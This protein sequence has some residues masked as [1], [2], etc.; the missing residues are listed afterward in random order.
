MQSYSQ[1]SSLWLDLASLV[2]QCDT[3]TYTRGLEL[4]RNQRVL[5][6]SIEPLKDVW[7]VMGDV[8]GSARHP[9]EVSIEVKRSPDGRVMEWDSDCTCPVGYQCKHGVALMIKAA[10][11]GQQ[12]LGG[13]AVT[14][15]AKPLTAQE[16]EAQRQA[17]LDKRQAAAQRQPRGPAPRGAGHQPP[18]QRVAAARQAQHQPSGR[19]LVS[20]QPTKAQGMRDVGQQKSISPRL[21]EISVREIGRKPGALQFRRGAV[22]VEV[23]MAVGGQY[24]K[25][26]YDAHRGQVN[27][28]PIPLRHAVIFKSLV[29]AVPPLVI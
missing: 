21:H 8:Q 28:C 23:R 15:Q 13:A 25:R 4:Y 20:A 11:K 17:E 5:N 27:Y 22:V 12:V 18:G 2:Q 29:L 1:T 26:Q 19:Q 9:Y 6:L 3:S 14:H 16:L 10:Y 7:L 24:D